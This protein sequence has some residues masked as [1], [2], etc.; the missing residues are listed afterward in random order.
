MT[1][2]LKVLGADSV[3]LIYLFSLLLKVDN[4][5]LLISNKNLDYDKF[6]CDQYPDC[7]KDYF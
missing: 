6:L 4:I 5:D 2:I 1:K 3:H 7:W